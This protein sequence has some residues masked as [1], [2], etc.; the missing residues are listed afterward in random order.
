MSKKKPDWIKIRAEYE[1][2]N[3]SYRA[4]AEKHDV[5]WKTLSARATREKWVQTKDKTKDKIRDRVGQK[6]IEK[7]SDKL[8]E[9]ITTAEK[10]T[11][12]A[13]EIVLR[14]LQDDKQ[15]QKHLIQRKEK[16][17]YED[18]ASK[19]SQWVEEQEFS[20]Y[21]SKRLHAAVSSL[22]IST[23]LQRLLKGIMSIQEEKKFELD[24]KRLKLQQDS[25]VSDI[26]IV[27]DPFKQQEQEQDDED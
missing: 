26:I 3:I 9:E 13:S 6:L 27:G 8:V 14:M 1:K 18:G 17:F 25:P 22:K 12:L 11:A 2:G 19:D 7:E 24:E 15:F 5:S 21:D 10:A 20:V 16:I 4:L 23:E